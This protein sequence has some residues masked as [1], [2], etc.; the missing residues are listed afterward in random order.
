[1]RGKKKVF[2][3]GGNIEGRSMARWLSDTHLKPSMTFPEVQIPHMTEVLDEE[4]E[5]LNIHERLKY[6]LYH[7]PYHLKFEEELNFPKGISNLVF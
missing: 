7:S 5:L 2:G 1:M 4:K 3:S 6:D